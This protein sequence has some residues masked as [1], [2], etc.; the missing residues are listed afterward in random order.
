[1]SILFR[2][3]KNK[4]SQKIAKSIAILFISTSYPSD[5]KDCRGRFIADMVKATS[6]NPDIKLDCWFPP[7][8]LPLEANYVTDPKASRH[9]KNLMAHGEIAHIFRTQNWKRYFSIFILASTVNI[10][11]GLAN[12]G[13]KS[14]SEISG[15]I[16]TNLEIF[17][18]TVANISSLIPC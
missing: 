5:E 3:M 8:D 10:L 7:G 4:H 16:S 18:I 6:T 14:S 9:L 2:S 13:F 11:S 17:V 15:A 1:M 12:N